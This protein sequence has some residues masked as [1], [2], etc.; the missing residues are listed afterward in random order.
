M[1]TTLLLLSVLAGLL[2]GVALFQRGPTRTTH[3]PITVYCAAGLKKPV[4]A[5]AEQY[6][7]ET[8]TEVRLQYGPTGALLSNIRV[9]KTGDLFIAADD[10]SVADARKFDVIREVLP[11]VRQHPVIAVRKGNPK[12]I[13]AIADLLREDVRL[14]V[15]N[16]DA[17]SIARV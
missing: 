6:R 14:A 5:I 17:A 4:E 15:A 11:L 16:P 9:A 10:G 3:T 8:G 7:R 12:N 13:H 1:R 2:V